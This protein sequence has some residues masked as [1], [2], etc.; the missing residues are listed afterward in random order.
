MKTSVGRE[1]AEG[2]DDWTITASRYRVSTEQCQP[3]DRLLCMEQCQPGDRL[4]CT[5]QCQPGDR[6]LCTEQC[7]PGDRLL[8]T[9][10]CQ[11]LTDH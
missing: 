11:P 7:Q 6:L 5:E 1:T 9:E 4:L 2:R 8:C 10:Q 3:G